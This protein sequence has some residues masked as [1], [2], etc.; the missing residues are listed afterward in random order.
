MPEPQ[1]L[2]ET[3]PGKVTP[4]NPPGKKSKKSK[5]KPPPPPAVAAPEP[6][7]PEPK[8]PEVQQPEPEPR[9]DT[10]P[11]KAEPAESEAAERVW[12]AG[13]QNMLLDDIEEQLGEWW[14]L[15][16]QMV[17][18]ADGEEAITLTFTCKVKPSKEPGLV[19]E[20]SSGISAKSCKAEHRASV[21]EG[22]RGKQLQLFNQ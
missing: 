5:D 18:L 10:E 17:I 20:V 22:K 2:D 4:L 8:P 12:G 1:S 11:Q 19:C 9:P 3:Q 13:A 16:E 6:K 7:P 15:L 14:G 21:E